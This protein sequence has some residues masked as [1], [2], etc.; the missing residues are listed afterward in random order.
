VAP[1]PLDLLQQLLETPENPKASTKSPLADKT[2]PQAKWVEPFFTRA[3][4]HDWAWIQKELSKRRAQFSINQ[5]VQ[6]TVLPITQEMAMRVYQETFSIGQEHILSALLKDQLAII[7]TATLTQAK[8]SQKYVITTP[9]GDIH[10]LGIAIAAA[11]I[12]SE[13]HDVLY[14]GPNTPGSDLV[15]VCMRYKPT[16]VLISSV[17]TEKEGA[18]QSFF[19]YIE[20]LDQHLNKSVTLIT[21]GRS[22][23]EVDLHSGRPCHYFSHLTALVEYLKEH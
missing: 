10:D 13:G 7:R 15:D 22:A 18:K 21:G 17:V 8:S 4:R 11:L 6:E 5:F 16:H 1:L 14:L 12:H 19:T 3:T 23:A 9:E 20:F 2:P